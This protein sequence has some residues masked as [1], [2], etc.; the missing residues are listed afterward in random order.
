MELFPPNF[1]NVNQINRLEKKNIPLPLKMLAK[2]LMM[3]MADEATA[4]FRNK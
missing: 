2:H 4:E 1:E 3:A